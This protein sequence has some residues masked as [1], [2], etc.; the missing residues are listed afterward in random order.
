MDLLSKLTNVQNSCLSIS[1][2]ECPISNIHGAD[3]IVIGYLLSGYWIFKASAFY[4]GASYLD[5]VVTSSMLKI[6]NMEQ[7]RALDAWTIEHEPVKSIDLM[8]R[9]CRAFVDWFT[10]HFE[11][12][13]RVVVVCGIGNN[14]GDGLGV[15]RLLSG[16][17]YPVAVWIVRGGNPSP[18]FSQNLSR[19]GK[20]T[21]TKDYSEGQEHFT[22]C[23]VIVDAIFG[24]GLT[25]PAEAI[26]EKAIEA[27][28]RTDAVRVAI[29]IPSGLLADKHTT[30]KAVQ[31]DNTITFQLPKLAFM[32]PE[33]E[34]HV[35]KWEVVDIGLDKSFIARSE[36]K[37]FYMT[38]DHA[39]SLIRPRSKFSHKGSNGHALLIAGSLGKMGAAVLA[40]R[41]ALRAGLG[42]LTVHAPLA[43]VSILQAGVPE[44]MVSLDSAEGQFSKAPNVDNYDVIGAGPGLGQTQQTVLA[45]QQIL[46]AGKPM[47]IDADALN[48]LSTHLEFLHLVPS[49]SIL[50][51]HPGEFERLVGKWNNDFDRLA[52]QRDLSLK[53]KSVVVVKGAHTTIVIPEGEVI[54]NCTGNPGMATGGTGDVLAG[55]LTGLLAQGYSARDAA[56]L[57]VYLHGLSGDLAAGVNGQNAM[58][59]GDIVDYL[60]A[61]FRMLE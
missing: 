18:D 61:A 35:G 30:G 47:V 10:G 7:V 21:K 24:S 32:L 26:F 8:E 28:N 48:I 29:D 36:S 51:P 3:Y 14:G 49:G 39:K 50:T 11:K 53:T 13:A 41:G 12:S 37:H 52:R 31:A 33:S 23:E 20:K 56:V 34:R 1:S 16:H 57:G 42:L 59:A 9:A 25:R 60:P 58:I 27:I 44:A 54:F 55:I 6:L 15:A 5:L 43:G 22:D 46:E 4:R 38:T 19:L 17:G 2:I 45:L 40:S